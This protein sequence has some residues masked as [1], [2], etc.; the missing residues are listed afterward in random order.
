MVR[1]ASVT[2]HAAA[3]VKNPAGVVA[4]DGQR[5]R[6]QALDVQGFGDGKLALGQGNRWPP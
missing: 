6:A 5:A 2:A 4:A 1:P 3:D